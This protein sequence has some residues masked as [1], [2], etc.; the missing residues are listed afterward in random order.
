MWQV[1][2]VSS[3]AQKDPECLSL[4]TFYRRWNRT[5]WEGEREGG[6]EGGGKEGE[7]E[8]QYKGSILSGSMGIPF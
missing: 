7:R 1:S 5:V 3:T 2:E 6:R 8:G 4:S